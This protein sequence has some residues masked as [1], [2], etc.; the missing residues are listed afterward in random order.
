VVSVR[1][2]RRIVGTLV[3][4]GVFGVG[5]ARNADTDLRVPDGTP[6]ILISVDTLRSDRLPVYGYDVVDTP[7]IDALRADG[8]LFE[9]AYTHVPLTLPA[10]VSL[11]TGVL[12]PDHGVRD[13]L[14]YTVDS[15]TAPMLQQTLR[16]AGYA[17]GA[18]VSA[19]VLRRATGIAAG[20]DYYDDRIELASGTTASGIQAVQRPGGDTFEAV[21]PWLRSVAD[22]PFLL[23]FHLF[24]PHTPYRPPAEFAT[25][26]RSPYDGEVAAADAVVGDLLDELRTLGVYDDALIVLLSDHGE[27]LGDHGESEHGVFL[28]RSTLQV[29]LIVKLPGALRAGQAV[30]YP[31]QLIDIFPTLVSALG[32]EPAPTLDGVPLFEP[33]QAPEDRPLYAETLFPRLHFGWSDLAS[34]IE[35]RHHF[36]EAPQPELYDLASDPDEQEN[37]VES[38]P[39]LAGDLRSALDAFDRTFS[40]PQ[41]TDTETRRMLEALGYVGEAT[42]PAGEALPDPKTRIDVLAKIREA[43]R[44]FGDGALDQAVAAFRSIVERDPGIEYAWEYI[45]LSQ[46]GLGRPAAAADTYR[47]A[48]RAVPHSGRLALRAATLALRMGRLDEASDLAARAVTYDASAAHGVLAQIAVVQGDLETA[49]REARAALSIDDRRPEAPVILADIL[50]ARGQAHEASELL[51]RAFE[52]GTAD[53]ALRLRLATASLQ[54]GDAETARAALAGLETTGDPAVLIAHGRLALSERRWREARGWFERTLE[55]DPSNAEA[56]LNLGLLAVADG[57]TAEAGPLLEEALAAHPYSFEGWNALGMVRAREGDNDRAIAAW[58]RAHQLRPGDIDV[59][60]NLGLAHAQAGR[61]REAVEYLEEYADRAEAGP[62]RDQAVTTA[63][64]LR[65]RASTGR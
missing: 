49:E 25:R 41:S 63:R 32:I 33:R 46:L 28:Y 17:T 42:T 55:V 30:S 16:E 10:H 43:H 54:I 52:R 4:V 12:P 3:V 9:R 27:G 34:V 18:A 40:A 21:R 31:V 57:R 62:Q 51:S 59:L 6:I 50:L 7:A 61:Y 24:E 65:A 15:E 58:K 64:E 11:L 1:A 38:R 39:D 36:I 47:E 23:L 19:F 44:L 37:L 26:Y 20:F 45:A 29:P 56:R 53:E 13:N 2:V 22:R 5:C 8:V 14:G 60:F 35:G 48:L